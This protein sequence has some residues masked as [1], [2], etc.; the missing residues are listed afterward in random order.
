MS[1]AKTIRYFVFS[2]GAAAYFVATAYFF[3]FRSGTIF[4]DVFYG[5]PA[6]QPNLLILTE[7]YAKAKGESIAS[8]NLKGQPYRGVDEY[9]SYQTGRLGLKPLPHSLPLRPELGPVINDVTS[10]RYPI[11]VPPC[12]DDQQFFISIIS[13]TRNSNRRHRVRRAWAS[14]LNASSGSYAFV[15][16]RPKNATVQQQIDEESEIFRDIIQID[17]VD[18][19]YNLSMKAAAVLNWIHSYCPIVPFVLKCDDDVFVNINNLIA[20][21]SKLPSNVAHIYG[22]L[23]SREVLRSNDSLLKNNI[24]FFFFPL[25]KKLFS[26]FDAAVWCSTHEL[27]PWNYYPPYLSGGSTLIGGRAIGPLLAAAQVTPFYFIDDL[28]FTGLLAKKAGVS[29]R[30]SEKYI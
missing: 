10:F 2:I 7:N 26:F 19:Y 22:A 16:G 13:S 18:A 23:T 15:M 4:G 5:Q 9:I 24:V 21:I 12:E 27:W 11:N 1:T 17:M 3:L 6:A 29:L 8:S 14:T 28:Y 20:V 30:L 25:Q